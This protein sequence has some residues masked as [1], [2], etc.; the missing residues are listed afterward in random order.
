MQ[1]HY[2]EKFM[3]NIPAAIEAIRLLKGKIE[4]LE[5]ETVDLRVEA[6]KQT[7]EQDKLLFD[8]RF[9]NGKLNEKIASLEKQLK[10]SEGI[11]EQ[12]LLLLDKIRKLEGD[13][14]DLTDQIELADRVNEEAQGRFNPLDKRIQ[15]LELELRQIAAEKEAAV[16]LTLQLQQRINDLTIEE[17]S[18]IEPLEE[19]VF[20]NPLNEKLEQLEQQAQ[21]YL[22]QKEAA[23]EVIRKLK[24][25]MEELEQETVDLR[26][27]AAKKTFEQD[28][29]IFNARLVN[30]QMQGQL[31]GLNQLNDQ[32]QAEIA[33]LNTKLRQA[34][35]LKDDLLNRIDDL[36]HEEDVNGNALQD[37]QNRLLAVNQRMDDLNDKIVDERLKIRKAIELSGIYIDFYQAK[38]EVKQIRDFQTALTIIARIVGVIVGIFGGFATLF[39]GC[40]AAGEFMGLTTHI[41]QARAIRSLERK[42][43][44]LRDDLFQINTQLALGPP[45]LFLSNNFWSLE[46]NPF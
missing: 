11:R 17:D 7:L 13:N 42:R 31:D 22:R 43:K 40:I 19:E 29:L 37:H 21:I 44:E 12:N 6:A 39:F 3:N 14:A 46:K 20:Q 1:S 26:V 4:E 32:N 27:E 25:K 36:E 23:I 24:T 35:Q 15:Q 2:L 38:E 8:A 30:G 9:S 34:A 45:P 33:A 16:A 5:Q 28:K 18:E 10:E 41:L